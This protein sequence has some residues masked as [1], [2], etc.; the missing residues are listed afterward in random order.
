MILR[1][2]RRRPVRRRRSTCDH[3]WGSEG[4]KYS[5]AQ[6]WQHQ[7]LPETQPE[8]ESPGTEQSLSGQREQLGSL[9][10][11]LRLLPWYPLAYRQPRRVPSR[12]TKVQTG[13]LQPG[14]R[15]HRSSCRDATRR[16]YSRH[17]H[18]IF[19]QL[20]PVDRLAI[21]EMVVDSASRFRANNGFQ[22]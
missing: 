16:P 22:Y 13:G 2:P 9:S 11:D 12:G 4:S 17:P 1:A 21:S 19:C 20:T 7:K 3:A 5:Q 18:Q 14:G 6:A 15:Y 10:G 8:S